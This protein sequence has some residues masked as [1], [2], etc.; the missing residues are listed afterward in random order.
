MKAVEGSLDSTVLDGGGRYITDFLANAQQA[1]RKEA[2]MSSPKRTPPPKPAGGARSAD[3]HW[4]TVLAAVADPAFIH[5]TEFRIRCA[6]R[7]YAALAGLDMAAIIGRPYWEIFPKGDGPLPGCAAAAR[8]STHGEISEEVSVQGRVFHCRGLALYDAA[9]VCQASIHFFEDISERRRQETELRYQQSQLEEIERVFRLGTWERDIV[10]DR[11][12]WS[13]QLLRIF[14]F[15]PDAAD[16]G[17]A[18]VLER[19]HPDDRQ[20]VDGAVKQTLQTGAPYD[21]V[22]RIVRPDGSVRTIHA[23]GVA[24][25]GANGRAERMAGTCQDIT[26]AYE[27]EQ[28]LKRL[29]RTYRTISRCNHHLIRARDEKSLAQGLCD[30]MVEEGGYRM[31]WVG[32]ALNDEAKTIL[33]FAYAGFEHGYLDGLKLTWAD[34]EFGNGPGARCIRDGTPKVT[35]DIPNDPNFVFWRE[36]AAKRGYASSIALPLKNDDLT[37]GFLG[38]YAVA[39]DAFDEEEVGL[40]TEV[41]DDLAYGI[42]TLRGRAERDALSQELA[43]LATHDR[44]TGLPNRPL[45]L[46]RLQQAV[47]YGQRYGRVVAVACLDLDNFKQ[48]NDSLGTPLGDEFLKITARRL[49]GLMR[50]NDTVARLASGEFI[51]VFTD[52]DSA[53]Q[54]TD[55]LAEVLA[56]VREP[57]KLGGREIA[58]TGSIGCSFCPDDGVEPELLLRRAKITLHRAKDMG[59]DSIKLFAAGLDAAASERMELETELRQAAARGQ[60]LL[61][62]QPQLD[63]HTGQLVGLEA[64]MRWRH[65]E[66]GAI[67]PA[68][69]IPIAEDSGLIAPLGDWALQ[70]ACR[71]ARSWQEMGIEGAVVAV[72]LS[73]RQFRDK[74]IVERIRDILQETGVAADRLELEI[75][76]GSIMHDIEHAITIMSDFKLLGVTLSI[77]D[78]GTGYSNLNYLRRFPV[79]TLKIDQSFVRDV[80]TTAS[81]AAVVRSVIVLGHSLHLKVI[82]E[83]VET[84]GQAVFLRQN[85]CDEIQGYLIARPQPAEDVQALISRPFQLPWASN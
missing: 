83:G 55:K 15:P 1:E 64:L 58:V 65:P 76:E 21:M 71:Q 75:T 16:F 10:N 35:H 78:F 36:E 34:T 60:L 12:K 62:Y 48:V 43:Y 70:T 42:T 85:G 45:L 20:R 77:D 53:A 5:D 33:P 31:A 67:S 8:Q 22:F 81:A 72:N 24:V 19:V 59:R 26:E 40:L 32:Y 4:P 28:R 79:D 11:P 18:T 54:T 56:A 84:V 82:A 13:K 37:F 44:L 29:N 6:N 23:A 38:M 69:F 63:L 3:Y 51:L 66:R 61:H 68:K 14:G 74:R 49:Q 7:A 27:A 2:A 25:P 9:G 30:T 47:L 46:D 50:D 52:Q 39:P 57:V 80:E 73:A 17:Y 41:A